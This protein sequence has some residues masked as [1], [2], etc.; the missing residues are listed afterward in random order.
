ML[1]FIGS[2]FMANK[3][4]TNNLTWRLVLLN[5]GISSLPAAERPTF[6]SSQSSKITRHFAPSDL[7]VLARCESRK[8]EG[9]SAADSFPS[10]SLRIPFVS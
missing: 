9:N 5:P 3:R 1:A 7:F 4:G 2:V 8:K 10:A 6:A